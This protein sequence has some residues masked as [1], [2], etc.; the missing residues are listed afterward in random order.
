MTHALVTGASR[1]IGRATALEL[2]RR[3][4]ELTLLGLPSSALGE[5]AKSTAGSVVECD[6]A[7]AAQVTSAAVKA[8]ALGVPDVVIHNAG[9][10]DRTS[11]EETSLESYERQMAINLRAPFLLTR[12][13][14]PA[15]RSQKRGRILFI[16]SITSTIGSRNAA[17]YAASKWGLLGL[18]KSLAEEL[19]ES[20]VV[21]CAI[22]P[23]SVDT[24]MLVGSGF[25]PRM[26][27]EDVA[28][29]I[30]WYALE[31][32]LAQNG[33]VVELFGT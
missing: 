23:G 18:M 19:S 1:G 12:E 15:L 10:I 5:V 17:V 21:T 7:D 27:A 11:I 28:L 9:V 24:E 13:L 22:L 20:G 25:A 4:V 32:P 30:A 2:A 33:G 8:L 14:L 16:G 3:G 6:L 31:A 29:T 26:S